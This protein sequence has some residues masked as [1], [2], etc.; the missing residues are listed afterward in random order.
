[1]MRDCSV[2]AM[3]D[4]RKSTSRPGLAGIVEVKMPS[5]VEISVHFGNQTAL[6][7][8]GCYITMLND[9]INKQ[10]M[11]KEQTE[12]CA[13]LAYE[14]C[15]TLSPLGLFEFF[16]KCLKGEFGDFYGNVDT[17]WIL[18]G[19]KKYMDEVQSTIR[20]LNVERNRDKRKR[21][22]EQRQK[23]WNEQHNQ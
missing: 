4:L 9:A 3:M 13:E 23:M 22:W 8:I 11:N 20:R 1:M 21:L 6:S 17:A 15:Y 7:I 2:P 18:N 14:V 12:M 19:L 5:L 16:V 10:R